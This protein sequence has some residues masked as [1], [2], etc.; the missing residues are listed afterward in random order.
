[1]TPAFA[2]PPARHPLEFPGAEADAMGLAMPTRSL[3]LWPKRTLW[4]GH[5]HPIVAIVRLKTLAG[6]QNPLP[7]VRLGGAELG[8]APRIVLGL[9]SGDMVAQLPR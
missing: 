4:A 3:P 6:N 7:A 1:M 5:A 8:M 2:G 9:Q